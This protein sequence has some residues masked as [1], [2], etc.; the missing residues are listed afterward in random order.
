MKIALRYVRL[1]ETLFGLS[2]TLR[3]TVTEV[4]ACY[5]VF[6]LKMVFLRHASYET[7]K[8]AVPRCMPLLVR[9]YGRK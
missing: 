5:G 7:V 6:G 1:Y 4:T 3:N 8:Y 9:C 2:S